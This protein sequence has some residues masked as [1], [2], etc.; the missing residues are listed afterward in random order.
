METKTRTDI[1]EERSKSFEKFR[2]FSSDPNQKGETL[3]SV[4][5]GKLSATKRLSAKRASIIRKAFSNDYKIAA[6][7]LLVPT[8][9]MWAADYIPFNW[10][11]FSSLLASHSKII[12]ITNK[13]S[14]TVPRCSF[15]NSL[16]GAL[17][18][19]ILPTPDV[20]I[21]SSAFCEGISHMISE[22]T[23]MIN[24]PH[25]H[26]DIPGFMEQQSLEYLT[27]QIE[28]MYND[29]CESNNIPVSDRESR[30]KL[31]YYNS[32]AAKQEF[33]KVHRL[34]QDYAPLNLGLE[35]LHWHMLFSPMWGHEDGYKLCKDLRIE[36]E[37]KCKEGFGKATQKDVP[38]SIFGL[39][40]Y[41]RSPIYRQLADNNVFTTFEGVNYLGEVDL[42]AAED[43][44]YMETHQVF[45]SIAKGLIQAPVRG[46]DIDYKV[47]TFV[48][49]A[50][51]SGA[52]G[53]MIFSH[54]HCQ[55]LA[56]RLEELEK[57][58]LKEGMSFVS[59]SGDTILGMPKGPTGIRLGTFLSELKKPMY[60]PEL[61]LL[62]P[63]DVSKNIP[64]VRVGI[65]F[66]SGFS[67]YVAI[68]KKGNVLQSE[69]FT[70]GIDYP[71][72]LEKIKGQLNGFT[73]V[74]Y[75]I[76]GIG[77]DN[78]SMH[79][80]V[81][82]STTEINALLEAVENLFGH[83]PSYLVVD[84]GT[85][86]VKVIKF[87][88]QQKSPYI[89]T[90]KSCGAGTGM[91]LVQILERWRQTR[92]ELAF[93]D[94]DEMAS[95]ATRSELLNTTCGIF[96]VTNVV[97]ALIQSN[98]ERRKEILRGAYDYIAAQAIRLLPNEDNNV[99]LLLVGGLARHNTLR[100]IFIEK[101]FE[102][103]DL[104]EDIPYQHLV[105]YGSALML[106]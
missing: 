27:M 60:T 25:F 98:D 92:S 82:N 28:K 20:A 57:T 5:P 61:T 41:G 37:T 63:K 70:S 101:G 65:D 100:S 55:M 16:K 43:I 39:V 99:P 48:K 62:K 51:K 13:G 34:R 7:S 104:P 32:V 91:V 22:L 90:N 80:L 103:L 50:A 10:E 40:P 30:I 77:S 64:E 102:L 47:S 18:E 84:I 9:I 3:N 83:L 81:D 15:I 94:L 67:K 79:V 12:E 72:L 78:E 85:Q 1:S 97:S 21:S 23:N 58:A 24:V 69:L 56:P 17:L 59:I 93:D 89:N 4:A 71:H 73:D 6:N 46:L 95:Q 2:K 75:S 33:L 53:F 76:A 105:S 29:L 35:P 86:D 87:Y 42:P 88:E 11:M 45:K 36:L 8:E 54:E 38:I 49:G 31:A 26:M 68:D 106:K 74:G 66:G 44:Q 19:E 96:A 14:S 52:K